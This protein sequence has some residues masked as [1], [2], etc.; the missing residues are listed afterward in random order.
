SGGP[1]PRCGTGAPRPDRTGRAGTG[2]PSARSRP[3]THGTRRRRPSPPPPA[4]PPWVGSR[5]SVRTYMVVR[6]MGVP[7]GTS[8]SASTVGTRCPELPTVISVGP[9]SVATA[10]QAGPAPGQRERDRVAGRDD[11]PGEVTG[12]PRVEVEAEQVQV[13]GRHLQEAVR[14]A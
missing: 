12:L 13:T 9:Y 11:Q 3:R 5:S 6:G 1:G 10:V 2:P 14:R 7:S 4:P 8:P